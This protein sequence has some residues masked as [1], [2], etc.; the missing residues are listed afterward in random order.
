[1]DHDTLIK[2]A[3]DL[4]DVDGS[5]SI[6]IV[7]VRKLVQICQGKKKLDSEA[8][9]VMDRLDKDHDGEVRL[10][11]FKAMIMKTQSLL[12]PAFHLQKD[13][14]EKFWGTRYWDNAAKRRK[15]NIKGRQGE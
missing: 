12:Y 9:Q 4:F 7:E 2:F 6:D 14:R 1:M 3:F 5:G 10:V 13:M 15:K 11:E 8:Q